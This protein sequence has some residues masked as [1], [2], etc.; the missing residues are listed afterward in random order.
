MSWL[1]KYNSTVTSLLCRDCLSPLLMGHC[2]AYDHSALCSVY[3]PDVA[4]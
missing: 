3:V 4:V 1:H 2:F